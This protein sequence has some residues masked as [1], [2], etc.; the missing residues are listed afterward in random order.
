M[1]EGSSP[2]TSVEKW[3]LPE[4]LDSGPRFKFI[5][6][7]L[8]TWIFVSGAIGRPFLRQDFLKLRAEAF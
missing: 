5:S 1:V 6:D 4:K 2:A 7:G 3:T 8:M